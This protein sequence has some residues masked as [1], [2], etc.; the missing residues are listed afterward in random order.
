[1][2][3]LILKALHIIF[4]VSY[5]AGLFYLVRLFVYYKDTDEFSLEKKE[6]L[7]K[8]YVF[9]ISRL[10]RFIT[11]PA[12]NLM[13]L[14]G[15]SL[16]VVHYPHFPLLSTDPFSWFYVKAFFLIGLFIYHEWCAR[17]VK[18]MEK[19]EGGDLPLNN[20]KLRQ[21]NEVATFLLFLIVFTVIFKSA[22]FTYWWQLLL[23]F[24][25]VV[26]LILGAV[27]LVNRRKKK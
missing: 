10:W 4:M 14:F 9:M 2:L 18:K 6:V 22:I 27:K 15:L 11:V 5:F 21:I 24:L 16:L 17:Q 3:Y 19:L 20:L 25:I 1:M 8:Q 23:G 7:R 12:F 26:G 13:L